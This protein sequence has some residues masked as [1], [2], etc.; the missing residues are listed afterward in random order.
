M[1]FDNLF[2]N[3]DDAGKNDL[4][5]LPIG[6]KRNDAHRAT[7]GEIK[8]E[9]W[10]NQCLE[11]DWNDDILDRKLTVIA[12][13]IL[14]ANSGHSP[15][16]IAIQEVENLA[17]LERL[18]TDYLPDAGYLPSV[19]IEGHDLRGID[20]PFLSRLPLAGEPMPHLP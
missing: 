3:K 11:W 7:C 4:T 9:R 18:R 20:V 10:R 6:A 12:G 8:V 2:D 16:I 1:N 5:Y 19:L 17:I 14:A 15:D 13:A